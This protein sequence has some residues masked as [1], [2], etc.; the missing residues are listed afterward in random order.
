M[1][2]SKDV[3][4]N[5]HFLNKEKPGMARKQKIAIALSEAR[6]AGANIPD[7]EKAKREAI[8]KRAEKY[9]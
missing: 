1:P 8:R 6:Q 9:A 5:M 7:P 4:K 2:H 3:G